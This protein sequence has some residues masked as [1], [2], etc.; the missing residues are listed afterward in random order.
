[1]I[2][3]LNSVQFIAMNKFDL[4]KFTSF[5]T[6]E[7]KVHWLNTSLYITIIPFQT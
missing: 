7:N 5:T 3:W 2:L 4:Q 6:F 1:M